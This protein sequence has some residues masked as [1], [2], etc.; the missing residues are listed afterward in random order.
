ME[1]AHMQ[2]LY[3]GA[4]GLIGVFLR[5]FLSLAIDGLSLGHFPFGT[6]A[7]NMLG[8][9]A[10]G[11]LF[12]LGVDRPAFSP[13]LRIGLM[14]GLL[15][16]FTTFSAYCQQTVQLASEGKRSHILCMPGVT[17]EKIDEFLKDL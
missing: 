15:G 9:C 16:G 10:A 7:V 4:F 17:R 8:A 1:N 2:L 12:A 6:F 11:Y 14:V 5:Y 3:I 13:E